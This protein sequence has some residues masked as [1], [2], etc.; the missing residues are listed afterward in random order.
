MA[1]INE[2]ANGL[3]L[4]F[5]D[6]FHRLLKGCLEDIHGDDW[7]EIGVNKHI[8]PQYLERTKQMLES[9]MKVVDM[10]KDDEELYGVEHLSNIVDG[11]WASLKDIFIDRDRTKVWLQ[12]IAE[13]RHNVSHRRKRHYLK[14]QELSRFA[15]NCGALLQALGSSQAERF[16]DINEVLLT[17]GSPWGTA[18]VGSLPPHDEVVEEFVGRPEEM[19]K[20]HEWFVSDMP[21][22]VITGYGGAGKSACAYQLGQDIKDAAP[23][24][25]QAVC[26]V[27]AKLLEYR[28]GAARDLAADFEDIPSFCAAVLSSMYGEPPTGI[29]DIRRYL[30]DE[31]NEVNI[32][33]IIDDF[34]TVM[35]NEEL[36]AFLLYDLRNTKSKILFTSRRT[37]PGLPQTEVD[38]EIRTGG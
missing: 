34:D 19:R 15:Q 6:E 11:N 31:L 23:T 38:P 1:D 27:S 24:E 13:V 8:G 9:P 35:D 37:V 17:G 28:G 33:L 36:T 14:R 25:L 7:L 16:T 4:D 5:L 20:L 12:E 30:L 21:Q 26:W 3:L 2:Y 18:P 29:Q 32:F 22:H 10:D